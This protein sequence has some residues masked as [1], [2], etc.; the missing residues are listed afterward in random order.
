M[1]RAFTSE[2][3]THIDMPP[4]KTKAG[5]TLAEVL[6]TL[7]IIGV[8]SAM[9]IPS[10]ITKYNERATVTKVKEVYSIIAQAMLLVEP[11]YGTPETWGLDTS[12]YT[13]Q[14][15]EKIGE[16]MKH[17]LKLSLDCGIQDPHK[18]CVTQ[19]RYPYLRGSGTT[20]S[21]NGDGFYKVVLSNG[22]HMW[23]GSTRNQVDFFFDVNGSLSPN[24]VGRDVFAITYF[25]G[26][27]VQ[28]DGGPGDA[29]PYETNCKLTGSGWGCA[30]YIVKFGN[31]NYLH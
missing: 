17:G 18:Q 31:M 23:M 6:V 9:T 21:Y 20:S 13:R 19:N 16:V 27:G 2:R 5:F 10:L 3:S 15:A 14:N 1:R 11:E 12:F 4:T 7:G 28:A 26:R 22:T 29:T 25:S 24:V 30:Y 8:I